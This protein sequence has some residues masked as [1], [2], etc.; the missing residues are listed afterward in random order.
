MRSRDEAPDKPPADAL[1]R[2]AR[3]QTHLL[4]DMAAGRAVDPTPVLEATA[5]ALAALDGKGA[6]DAPA[7]ESLRR[8]LA[9]NAAI[10][11]AID[12]ELRETGRRL[13]EAR[14]ASRLAG[15]LDARRD[16]PR[17]DWVV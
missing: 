4:A 1:E 17:R 12:G 13:E 10:A 3:L 7:R 5:A 11:S 6:L 8:V 9:L 2:A 15:E 14:R 16:E